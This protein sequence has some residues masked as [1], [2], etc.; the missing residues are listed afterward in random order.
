MTIDT[1]NPERGI[2]VEYL[3]TCRSW[4]NEYGELLVVIRYL[5]VGSR[6]YALIRTVDEFDQ[7]ISVCPEG[8]DIIVFKDPLLPFRGKC[9]IALV[10][11]IVTNMKHHPEYLYV[12]TNLEKLGD[13]RLFGEEGYTKE[14]LKSDLEEHL[15]ENIAVG[16][17][18]NYI[19]ED[20]QAMISASKGGIDGPR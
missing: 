4:I 11:E 18:P 8:A 1:Y 13:P 3:S 10:S 17:C 16:P 2:T 15:G 12:K 20:Q 5:R 7:L 14:T 6:D 19:V 9:S